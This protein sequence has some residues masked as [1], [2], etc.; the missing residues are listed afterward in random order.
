M[1]TVAWA[2]WE[3]EDDPQLSAWT[4]AH[5]RVIPVPVPDADRLGHAEAA[6]LDGLDPP[7]DQQGRPPSPARAQ[8]TELRRRRGLSPDADTSVSRPRPISEQGGL[9][10]AMQLLWSDTAGTT[11]Q[12]LRQREPDGDEQP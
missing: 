11:A 7:L 2:A 5:L 10:T 12:A 3:S 8:L 9:A 6:V 1:Y 4:S